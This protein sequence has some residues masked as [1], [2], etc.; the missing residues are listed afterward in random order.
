M[1]KIFLI[2]GMGADERL[3]KNLSLPDFD[4]VA[5][6][7]I[8]PERNDTLATYATKLIK[9]FSIVPQS[10]LIGVSLGG[11]I[12]VEIAKQVQ[13][14]HVFIISTIKSIEEAPVFYKFFRAFPVYK[15]LSGKLIIYLG[16]LIKPFMGQI[17]GKEGDLFYRMLK[18]TSPSFLLWSMHAALYWDN[19][20]VL[21]NIVHFIGDA[22]LVFSYKRIKDAIVIPNG[23]HVMVFTH[24][25]EISKLIKEKLN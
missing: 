15:F 2:S 23:T 4:L 5:I 22:D 18:N 21:T 3:F 17:A 1:S 14:K 20:I 19:V 13:L 16:F 11:M 6:Y 24:G 9:H 25:D 10:S 12:S 7:W 8:E